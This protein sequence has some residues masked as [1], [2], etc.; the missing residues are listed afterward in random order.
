LPILSA[1]EGKSQPA[2][3]PVKRPPPQRDIGHTQI[4]LTDEQADGD[5]RLQLS[6]DD[7][8]EEGREKGCFALPK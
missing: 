8:M 7:C 5:P 6:L 1:S 3:G 2:I 4:A